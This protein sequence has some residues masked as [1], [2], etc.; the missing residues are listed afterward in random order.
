[1]RNAAVQ[2]SIFKK[3]ERKEGDFRTLT[4]QALQSGDSSNRIKSE[5]MNQTLTDTNKDLKDFRS[6]LSDLLFNQVNKLPHVY[7]RVASARM[8]GLKKS[9]GWNNQSNSFVISKSL[10]WLNKVVEICFFSM[11][12]LQ[13]QVKIKIKVH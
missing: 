12:G 11:C 10:L 5:Q 9:L 4:R 8:G 13:K 6:K 1:V 3:K 7:K 2:R